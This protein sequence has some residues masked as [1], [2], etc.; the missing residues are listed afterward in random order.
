[1]DGERSFER[2]FSTS[3]RSRSTASISPSIACRRHRDRWLALAVA[4][5]GTSPC[6]SRTASKPTSWRGCGKAVNGSDVRRSGNPLVNDTCRL[7]VDRSD[8]C[9]RA[10]LFDVLVKLPKW[11]LRNRWA[12]LF[13]GLRRSVSR[14]SGQLIF[15]TFS[16]LI[17]TCRDHWRPRRGPTDAPAYTSRLYIAQRSTKRGKIK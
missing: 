10:T 7:A 9:S 1:V 5:P 11:A 3:Q 14:R 8:E 6:S 15:W 12:T 2:S 13:V 17:S 16:P 4:L